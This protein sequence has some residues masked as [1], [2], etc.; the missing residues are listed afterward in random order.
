VSSDEEQRRWCVQV[1]AAYDEQR[2][3]ETGIDRLQVWPL[4]TSLAQVTSD[5]S[6]YGKDGSVLHQGRY[7][8][9]LRRRRD[10]WKVMTFAA[11][12]EPFS[13]PGSLASD[14]PRS[15]EPCDLDVPFRVA[16]SEGASPPGRPSPMY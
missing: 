2:W 4:S 15:R 11:V 7:S 16:S 3:E 12:E 14:T 9:M 10:G 1:L 13:G 5:I 8:Y 6:R